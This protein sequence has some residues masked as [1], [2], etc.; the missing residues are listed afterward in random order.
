MWTIKDLNA[1][2]SSLPL[3]LAYHEFNYLMS[4]SEK[5][6]KSPLDCKGIQSVSPKGNQ[7][8]IFIERI[9]AEAPVVWPPDAKSWLIAENA[10]AG[11][12]W[13]H[14]RMKWLDRITDSMHMSL[15]KLREIAKDM[16]AWCAAV[17]EVAKSLTQLSD[18]KQVTKLTQ[19]SV[20]WGQSFMALLINLCLLSLQKLKKNKTLLA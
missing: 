13:R 18:W 2:S 1:M 19:V 7:S 15:S 16:E 9:D 3:A 20:I 14:Q 12:D 4:A 17:H 10:D 11:K 5:T 6:L 8:W